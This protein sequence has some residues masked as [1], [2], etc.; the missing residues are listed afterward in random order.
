MSPTA[1]V[2]V[3]GLLLVDA[4]LYLFFGWA[5]G[6][7]NRWIT[8]LTLAFIAANALLTVTDEFG[9]ADLFVLVVDAVIVLLILRDWRVFWPRRGQTAHGT[10]SQSGAK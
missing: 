6:R 4:A 8:L 3:G 5:I 9:L 10:D 2:I 7:R 1:L